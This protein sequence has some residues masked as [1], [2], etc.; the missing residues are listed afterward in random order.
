MFR[1][2]LERITRGMV[3]RRSLPTR[4]GSRTIYVSPD[5]RLAYLFRPVGRTD[6]RLLAWAVER[7]G[8][9]DAVWDVGSNCG[10]FAAAA[11]ILAGESGSVVALEP[12]PF[13]V[14]LLGRTRGGLG[15]GVATIEIVQAAVAERA[16][17][18]EFHIASRGRAASW[19]AGS[20]P[21]TQASGARS[22][23]SVELV[24]LDGLLAGRRPPS[25]I[26]IDAE[27]SESR[28]LEGAARLLDEVRPTLLIEVSAPCADV[29]AVQLLGRG[30][31]LFDAELEPGARSQL[32]RPAA[33][34]LALP[35]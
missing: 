26:K 32:E 4:F 20:Q 22:V 13:L 23:L 18:E 10:V 25:L 16:G 3:L 12:D 9:G 35:E 11:A 8:P 15:V 34:T 14:G 5:A 33:N 24:T 29:V 31:R 27:G 6:A 7:V 2:L 30:Y 28:I 17:R 21:S 1:R 19:L